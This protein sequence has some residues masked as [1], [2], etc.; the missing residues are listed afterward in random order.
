MDND[1]LYLT[2]ANFFSLNNKVQAPKNNFNGRVFLTDDTNDGQQFELYKDS[3]KP[4][5]LGNRVSNMLE[6]TPV[7]NLFFS[8][9]NVD[10]IQ[11]LLKQEVINRTNVDNDPILNGY[12]PI[13]I[14]RQN[15]TELGII[16]RSIYL[17]YSKNLSSNI[18]QQVNELNNIVIYDSVPK[19]ITSIKQKIKYYYDIQNNPVPLDYGM[20]TSTKGE[21]YGDISELLMGE[22]SGTFD[23]F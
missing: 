1:E 13:I 5:Y 11:L 6:T 18:E 20:N 23:L 14:K 22:S 16:M 12:K 4:H 15:D 7:S 21:N 17:Q 8:K 3:T 19:I 9:E 2:N 10:R